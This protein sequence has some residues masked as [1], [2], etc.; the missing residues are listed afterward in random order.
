MTIVRAERLT[1]EIDGD[2]VVFLIG[3]R[4]NKF[5]KPHKWLLVATAMPRMLAEL[6]RT[7]ASGLLHVRS[8]FG[9]RNIVAVQ[10]WRSFEH[11]HAYAIARDRAHLPAWQAFNR[12]IASSGDVGIWHETYLVRS[13]K[14]ESVYNNMPP[15]GLGCAGKLVPAQGRKANAKNRLGQSDPSDPTFV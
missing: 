10:Y 1:A 9:L 3:V 6:E 14:H 11:L 12:A 13:G 7:P 15:Y 4:I 2:F 5:W 8:H